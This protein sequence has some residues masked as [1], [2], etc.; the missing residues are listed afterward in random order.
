[1]GGGVVWG[2]FFFVDNRGGF[3]FFFEFEFEPEVFF[4]RRGRGE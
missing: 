2:V 4:W 3:V 1:V